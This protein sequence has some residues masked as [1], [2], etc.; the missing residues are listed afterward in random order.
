MSS[1]PATQP[2]PASALSR[3]DV[4]AWF[5]ATRAL[6]EDL[7]SPLSPEDQAL[8]SMPDASPAKW[9]RAHTS[10]FFETFILSP[11][12]QGYTPFDP[13]YEYL[14]NSYY[15]AVGEQH[16]RPK[17]GL[18]TRPDSETVGRYRTHVNE[19]MA[20]L[21]SA[22]DEDTWRSIAPLVTLGLHHEQQHQ[23]LLLMDIL[24]GFSCNPLEPAYAGTTPLPSQCAPG[25][26]WKD[27]AGGLVEIGRN[28]DQNGT[29]FCFDNEGPRHQVMLSPFRMANRLV[30]NEEWLA[31]MADDGY[32]RS[33]LWLSDGWA[34]VRQENWCAPLYWR[35]EGDDTWTAFS[36]RGRQPV[37]PDA[38]VCHIS[39]YE[40]DAYATWAGKRLPTE[41][42]W[43]TAAS[44]TTPEGCFLSRR[45]LRPMPASEGR[46]LQQLFGD[47]WEYTRSPY[48]PYP[49]FKAATGA[50]GEYN[51]KFMSNQMVLR[52]G[53]CVTP[54]GHI[55]ATYR[56]FYYPHQRWMFAGLRLAD[57]A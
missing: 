28:Q 7:A 32:R 36:L 29:A 47:V 37:N 46:G 20:T 27:F 18:L 21:L 53:C 31:F 8:Q 48:A 43:E 19:T 26:V 34:L 56:N 54:D 6:T 1:V 30:T 41:A 35:H 52:G 33:E 2:V 13:H 17:R 38:P 51:G 57:E 10:W 44:E 25:L 22:A 40:A 50:I 4:R 42:E 39:Y 23:E 49:G 9:H 24:H 11:F 12:L 16:P 14:F 15:N 45:T 55:R 5:H 3:D